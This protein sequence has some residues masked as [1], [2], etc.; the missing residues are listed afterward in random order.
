[1]TERGE[2]RR[3]SNVLAVVAMAILAS[4]ILVAVRWGEQQTSL[5]D[6]IRRFNRRWF[7]PIVLRFAGNGPWP[8]ARL[9]HR[10]RR[11]SAVRATPLL[12]WPAA[13][14]FVVPMPYGTGVDWARNLLHAGDGALLFQGVRY[15][16]GGPRIVSV[17]QIAGEIPAFIGAIAGGAGIRYLMRVDVLPNLMPGEPPSA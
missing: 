12:V 2:F 13:G 7:N 10:G 8:V 3:R 17:E 15:R 6:A 16:V 5:R 4:I 1:M 11:S 9:E 14:G